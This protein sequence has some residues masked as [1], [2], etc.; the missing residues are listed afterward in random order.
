M[1]PHNSRWYLA[2][3]WVSLVLL[4]FVAADAS[5]G[6]SLLLLAIVALIPPILMMAL[7]KEPQPT[8][9]EVL[10]ATERRR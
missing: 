4:A 8:M 5:S 2:A 3:S 6:R 10:R 9:A 1:S 7:W